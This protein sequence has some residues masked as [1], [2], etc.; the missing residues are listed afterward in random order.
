M[1]QIIPED[2]HIAKGMREEGKSNAEVYQFFSEKYNIDGLDEGK[3]TAVL[4]EVLK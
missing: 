4:E 1:R 2:K 3:F